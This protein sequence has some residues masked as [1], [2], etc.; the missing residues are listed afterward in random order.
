MGWLAVAWWPGAWQWSSLQVPLH[1][2]CAYLRL[3]LQHL[4]GLMLHLMP[5]GTMHHIAIRLEHSSYEGLVM[6]RKPADRA[7]QLVFLC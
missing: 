7:K 5:A 3:P 2:L 6:P 4:P 1:L